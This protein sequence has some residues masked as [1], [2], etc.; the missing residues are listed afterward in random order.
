MAA[1]L[2]QEENWSGL[3]FPR[4]SFQKRRPLNPDGQAG[5]SL[6]LE[7]ICVTE[8]QKMTRVDARTQVPGNQFVAQTSS[9]L[10]TLSSRTLLLSPALLPLGIRR[11]LNWKET[12]A[13]G[14]KSPA[15]SSTGASAHSSHGK[16]VHR[17][18]TE[19]RAGPEL[20]LFLHS[21]LPCRLS[22]SEAK[23]FFLGIQCK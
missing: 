3:A 12:L 11:E 17:H 10:A 1:L 14:H 2:F 15:T 16:A 6:K 20:L 8:M 9:L 21:H 19:H 4:D 18:W 7:R 5:D 23:P 22:T 13:L